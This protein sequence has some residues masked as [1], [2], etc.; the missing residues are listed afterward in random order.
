MQ[1]TITINGE[2]TKSEI[3]AALNKVISTIEADGIGIMEDKTL[4]TEFFELD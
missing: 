3:L 1:Y 4:I 2:G